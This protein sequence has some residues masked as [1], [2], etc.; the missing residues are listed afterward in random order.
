M[1]KVYGKVILFGE[2]FVAYQ[3]KAIASSIPLSLEI[4]LKDLPSG[5]KSSIILNGKPFHNLTSEKIIVRVSEL[6]FIKDPFV[7]SVNSDIPLAA[8]LGSSSAFIVCLLKTLSDFYNLRMNLSDINDAAFSIEKELS[9]IISGIDNTLITY[10]GVLLFEQGQHKRLLLKKPFKLL[11]VNSGILSSTP[12]I[13]KQTRDYVTAHSLNFKKLVDKNNSIVDKAQE[14]L[15]RADLPLLGN[16]MTQSHMLL[17]QLGVSHPAVEEIIQ[18]ARDYGVH[19]AKVTGAGCGGYVIV[20]GKGE[21]E[22][23]NLIDIFLKKGYTSQEVI[24]GTTFST[25]PTL[26]EQL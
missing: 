4:F 22:H 14:A 25:L 23:Q 26:G 1:A 11:L 3:G 7:I 17:Q 12:E 24:I 5:Q 18:I 2:H 10:G 6:L 19:G 21:K 9:S 15:S 16:L 20:L 8:G 13:L